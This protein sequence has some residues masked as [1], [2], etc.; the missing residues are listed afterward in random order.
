MRNEKESTDL[1]RWGS[2]NS[3][4]EIKPALFAEDV[5]PVCGNKD[6][7][8]V[9]SMGKSNSDRVSNDCF[10]DVAFVT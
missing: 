1:D 5:N 4:K 2:A 9:N 6:K 10:G 3:A 7:K 8:H